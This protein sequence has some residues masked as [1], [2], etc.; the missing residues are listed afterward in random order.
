VK[1]RR[2][3][4]GFGTDVGHIS[5]ALA[6]DFV[7]VDGAPSGSPAVRVDKSVDCERRRRALV[8]RAPV[9]REKRYHV[10]PAPTLNCGRK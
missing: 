10:A 2:G 4:A 8:S 5:A 6:S 3:G 9:S 1:R 7:G